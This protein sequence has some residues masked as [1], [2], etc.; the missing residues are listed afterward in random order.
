MD[1]DIK[2]INLAEEGALRIE[3]GALEPISTQP[4]FKRTGQFLKFNLN[5]IQY[6]KSRNLLMGRDIFIFPKC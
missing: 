4:D 5:L 6:R 1:Y 2:D 3:S